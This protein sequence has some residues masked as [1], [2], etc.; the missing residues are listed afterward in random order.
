MAAES[1]AVAS[2]REPR[3]QRQKQSATRRWTSLLPLALTGMDGA[4]IIMVDT[5][6]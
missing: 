6:W 4:G 1:H 5:V 2:A 3:Q